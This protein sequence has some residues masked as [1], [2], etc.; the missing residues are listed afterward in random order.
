MIVF[1]MEQ[2]G[3]LKD[4]LPELQGKLRAYVPSEN[5]HASCDRIEMEL[6]CTGFASAHEEILHAA[7]ITWRGA[8]T[9]ADGGKFLRCSSIKDI[10]F[11]VREF[12]D[13]ILAALRLP[14][15]LLN[16]D[17]TI[18]QLRPDICV[19]L[20]DML[21]VVGVVVFKEPD[22]DVLLQ[23]TVLGELM[24]H[25]VL[26]EGFYG[27]G[28]II[29][30]LT[31][32]A[33]W[34][35][36]WFPADTVA[37][38]HVK[39]PFMKRRLNSTS[40]T[41][42]GC[43]PPRET[44]SQQRG[45]VH[46]IDELI[47]DCPESIDEA[48]VA[49]DMQDDELNDEL[50]QEM[51]RKLCTTPVMNIYQEPIRVLQHLCHAFQLMFHAPL[52][53]T[54]G[55]PRCLLKLHKDVCRVTFHPASYDAVVSEV[56]FNKFPSKDVKTLVALEDLGR[57]STGKAWLCVTMT[58]SR[59]ASCVLK[60]DNEDC[61]S[62]RL[63]ME[64]EMWHLIYPEFSTMV[65]VEHWSGA[66]ALVMPHFSTVLKHERE[67]YKAELLAVL[68]T[69][70]MEKGKVHRDVQWRNIGKYRKKNGEVALVVFDLYS[71]VDYNVDAH[72]DW[73][74]NAMKVLFLN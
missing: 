22:N 59:S 74:D 34:L 17:V 53:H 57:G 37:L 28:P 58:K 3:L 69:R 19:L 42:N 52:D 9:K 70:F 61:V 15:L 51:E 73:I 65:K 23:P 62:S 49:W 24:D 25:M 66:D 46:Y 55:L 33:E 40:T 14:L 43:N 4:G 54:S 6:P 56:D 21:L 29:G 45:I 27:V 50:T 12:L 31:T 32:G 38:E 18:K 63:F 35:V 47:D 1:S 48:T 8:K 26:V 2:Y 67:Q 5:E 10:V 13:D 36:S 7:N 30:I 39:V 44:P 20:K 68:T 72:R 11:F 71:V 64:R 41:T 60:F 16:G